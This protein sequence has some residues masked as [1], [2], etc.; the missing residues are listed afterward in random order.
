MYLRT[1]QVPSSNGTVNEYVRVVEAFRHDGKVQQRTI[2]DLG[3]TDRL[4]AMLPQ[5]QRLL[6]GQPRW[7]DPGDEPIDVPP[8]GPA[9]VRPLPT[10]PRHRSTLLVRSFATDTWVLAR[11]TV[12][13]ALDMA[14]TRNKANQ[15]YHENGQATT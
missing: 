8:K 6:L 12:L 13:G 15:R 3:R 10:P 2:A 9:T 11:A 5:L 14:F 1:V 4:T 7:P